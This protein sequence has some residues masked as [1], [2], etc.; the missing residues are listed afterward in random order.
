MAVTCRSSTRYSETVG[1]VVNTSRICKD[2][3]V[4]GRRGG[5]LELSVQAGHACKLC[6]R[7]T[8]CGFGALTSEESHLISLPAQANMTGL[9]R[10]QRLRLEL[11]VRGLVRL[12]V[13]HYLTIPILMLIGALL[14]DSL[15]A[16]AGEGASIAGAAV[17]FLMGCAVLRLYD[18]RAGRNWLSRLEMQRPD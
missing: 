4:C 6:A 12:A 14:G 1:S 13:F 3:I 7:G 11:P 2:A 15:P 8:G 5:K 18:S 16:V 10:G 9:I 17:G